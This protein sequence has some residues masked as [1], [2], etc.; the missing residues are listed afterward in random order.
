MQFFENPL[1]HKGN[2][3]DTL[4]FGNTLDGLY[5]LALETNRRDLFGFSLED[6]LRDFLQLVFVIGQIMGIP[7]FRELFNEISVRNLAVFHLTYS[8]SSKA[9]MFFL[10]R[11]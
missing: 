8:P 3:L 5:L 6:R 7:K 11:T 10:S 9:T 1:F 4:G 2:L